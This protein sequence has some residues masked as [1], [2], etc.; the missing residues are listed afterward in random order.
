ME[1]LSFL[2]K[3]KILF[4]NI[5]AHPLF[6][7]LFFVPLIIY[8]LQ[9]KHGKR[10]FIIVYFIIIFS[11]L[12]AFG[13][14]I[15]KL[16]DNLMD[17]L[18]MVLYFP[19]FITL[20][21]IVLITSIF[22]LIAI[23][24]TKMYKIN[25]VI[26]Y[27]SFGI[28]Q[29]LFVLILITIKINKINVYMSNA[30]YTNSDVLSLMQLLVGV[31][32]LQMI[33][34][35]VISAVNR[36]TEKLDAKKMDVQTDDFDKNKSFKMVKINNEKVGFINVIDSIK[37]GKTK[38]KPFKFDIN[39]IESISLEESKKPKLYNVI[40]LE[41]KNFSYLNEMIKSNKF[42][43]F[44]LDFNKT[45]N[46][47]L[48][49][50]LNEKKSYR[51]KPFLNKGFVYLNNII[52]SSKFKL[53]DLNHEKAKNVLLDGSLDKKKTFKRIIIEN[54]EFSYLNEI[55]KSNNFRLI[56]LNSNKLQ[57]IKLNSSFDKKKSYSI[58]PILNKG[59]AYLNE[60]LSGKKIKSIDLD[61]EKIK[62]VKLDDN[63]RKNKS[64][65]K[66]TLDLNKSY[67]INAKPDL[68]RPMSFNRRFINKRILVI[69]NNMISNVNIINMQ[70]A[71]DVFSKYHLI[72]D[73]KLKGFD[74]VLTIDNLKISNFNLLLKVVKKY[75]IYR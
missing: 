7:L 37:T 20:F 45:Q 52:R 39:K 40:T 21:G 54:R 31:F 51:I 46:I 24:S 29:M 53:F 34:I 14:V 59:F 64:F 49:N 43:L 32:V 70:L 55:V 22:A 47:N 4:D 12:I 11:I 74:N 19:N 15:F 72:K 36:I 6:T 38:L 18:F 66:V 68:M 69:E 35:S 67:L 9:K 63:L 48:N 71:I 33:S 58:K 3:I 16:F 28:I 56:G 25:K 23:F 61:S 50:E 41:N 8:F 75:K 13:D 27:V 73:I 2:D 30:L 44:E 1:E 57:N 10:V 60:V 42:K 5:L 26:N 65:N 17:G 62:H